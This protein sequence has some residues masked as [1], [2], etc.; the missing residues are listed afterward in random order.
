MVWTMIDLAHRKIS[1]TALASKEES[2]RQVSFE[3]RRFAPYFEG[4]FRESLRFF[5]TKDLEVLLGRQ[6]GGWYGP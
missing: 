2:S 3:I 1:L 5:L 4:S 6:N